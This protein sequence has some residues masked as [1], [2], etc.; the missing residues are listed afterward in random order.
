MSDNKEPEAGYNFP[1]DYAATMVHFYR[2]ELGR[3]MVWRQ[4]FDTTTHW[5]I[6]GMMGI[7]SFAWNHAD[8]ST[9]LF[10]FAY[11]I[12]YLLLT[13][14]ARRYRFYDAYRARVRMLESHFIFPVV[15]LSAK[16]LEGNWRRQMGE[17]LILPSYKITFLEALSRRFRRNYV[18]IFMILT[19]AW[20]MNTLVV[21]KADSAEMFIH[22]FCANQ[23]LPDYVF[24]GI[25]GAFHLYFIFLYLYGHYKRSALGEFQKRPSSGSWN[26]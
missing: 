6:I 12:L 24:L 2:G 5:A 9:F 18:W 23:P 25:L 26:I 15:T 4:R 13:I 10:F 21:G 20:I 3:M 19:G 8:N 22:Q 11:F 1:K 17:D 16:R 7:V 14:E